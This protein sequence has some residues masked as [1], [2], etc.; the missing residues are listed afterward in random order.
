[1]HSYTLD[2]K[3]APNKQGA[4]IDAILRNERNQGL[5][6]DIK[7]LRAELI[8][9]DLMLIYR[10]KGFYISYGKLG[11]SVKADNVYS[12]ADRSRLRSMEE[13]WRGEGVIRKFT[14]QGVI[15]RFK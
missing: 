5:W 3:A 14:E 13:K 7:K 10:A 4:R 12:V 9:L 15:Y 2:T 11:I 8:K 6:P 1:M